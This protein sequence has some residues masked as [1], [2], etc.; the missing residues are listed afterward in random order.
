MGKGAKNRA[1][2]REK[3]MDS[4]P[5]VF[6]LAFPCS[7]LSPLS[8]P[9]GGQRL[10]DFSYLDHRRKYDVTSGEKILLRS[11]RAWL[12]LGSAKCNELNINFFVFRTN[13]GTEFYTKCIK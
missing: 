7:R 4:A 10:V 1:T 5:R 2:A 3:W 11:S 6:S 9:G 12:S 8:G 13:E